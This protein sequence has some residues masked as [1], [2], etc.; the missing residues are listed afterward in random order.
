MVQVH[1]ALARIRALPPSLRI[2][3]VAVFA[4]LAG[5]AIVATIVGHPDRVALFAA[6]LHSEQ[7]S[8][9]QEQLAAWSVPFSPTDDNVII[10]AARRNDLLLRL[11]LAGVPHAHVETTG[12][13]LACGE[14]QQ[15]KSVLARGLIVLVV[16]D[17]CAEKVG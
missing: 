1:S 13:A 17:H 4:L 7:L 2:T 16:A 8:E 9:V 3:A 12:E 15:V 5:F 11:S 6:P 10:D 14:V